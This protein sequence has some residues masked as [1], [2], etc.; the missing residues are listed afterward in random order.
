MS[1]PSLSGLL[2]ELDDQPDDTSCPLL[3]L[4]PANPLA[5][6]IVRLYER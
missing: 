4:L 5:Y 2:F 1:G 6:N 3:L